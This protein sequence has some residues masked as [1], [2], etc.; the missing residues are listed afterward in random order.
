[1]CKQ[2]VDQ[3]SP[4]LDQPEYIA[5]VDVK[6]DKG[7]LSL[8]RSH[9]LLTSCFQRRLDFNFECQGVANSDPR[10]MFGKI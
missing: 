9:E 1:M 4:I 7:S 10:G 6:N 2:V 5:G 3:D 8:H